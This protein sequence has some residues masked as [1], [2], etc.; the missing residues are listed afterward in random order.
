[1]TKEKATACKTVD[2]THLISE[3][4]LIKFLV[5]VLRT[6]DCAC[7]TNNNWRHGTISKLF[8][9]FCLEG[10]FHYSEKPDCKLII[11]E[12]LAISNVCEVT[13]WT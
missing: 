8:K 4:R 11:N 12:T 3:G 7:G 10:R 1:M 6:V 5:K 9:Y 13:L 2:K